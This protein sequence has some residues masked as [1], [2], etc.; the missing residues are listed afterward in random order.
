MGKR[1]GAGRPRHTGWHAPTDVERALYDARERGD[2]PAYL[3]TLGSTWLYYAVP[4][5]P[6]DSLGQVDRYAY[7]DRRS[8]RYCCAVFTHG[9]L[10]APQSDPVYL[11]RRLTDLAADWGNDL[12]WLAVNPGSPCEAYFPGTLDSRVTWRQHGER[13][14]RSQ[15]HTLR[16]LATGA[17]LHGPVAHGLACGALLSVNNG[18]LWNAMAWHGTGYGSEVRRLRDAWGIHSRPDWMHR[19]YELLEAGQHD[20][21]WEFVLRVRRELADADDGCD[22]DGE[23]GALSSA[24]GALRW[25]EATERAVRE[26]EGVQTAGPTAPGGSTERAGS[27]VDR[28]VHA[29]QRVISRIARYESRFRADG[30]LPERGYVRSVLAWDYGR[31]AKMARWGLGARYCELPEAEHAVVRA[32]ELSRR[33]YGTWED[34]SAGF[35]LGRCLHF[36]NEEFGDWYTDMLDAHRILT[37]HPGSPWRNLPFT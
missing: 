4:R 8:G 36:D 20:S 27:A 9:M 29:L 18:S 22:A 26:R 5:G 14:W 25:R 6:Y 15:R 37:T 3:D 11:R 23:G 24:A 32:G 34:F 10:P 16:T 17:P 30:L 2:W 35:V 12:W 33:V 13:A 21:T 1:N 7:K 31:A 28:R 19:Q